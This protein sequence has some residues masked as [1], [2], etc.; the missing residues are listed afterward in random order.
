MTRNRKAAP[1]I[2]V[3]LV[4]RTWSVTW[5]TTGNCWLGKTNLIC[6]SGKE[7]TRGATWARR[8]DKAFGGEWV[9]SLDDPDGVNYGQW[10]IKG[11]D[12]V[13]VEFDPLGILQGYLLRGKPGA[14][15]LAVEAHVRVMPL[16]LSD[17]P[18]EE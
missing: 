14:L 11:F 15:Q 17:L 5:R 3:W 2:T 1:S 13:G 12:T 18:E 7:C 9:V 4:S 8:L 16:D 6:L 10:V